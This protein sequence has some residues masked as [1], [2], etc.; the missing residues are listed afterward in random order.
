MSRAKKLIE[1]VRAGGDPMRV[2]NEM[3]KSMTYGNLP[4]KAEFEKAFDKEVPS[5]KYRFGNDERFGNDSVTS[6][7][8][9]KELETAVEEYEDG[10]DAAGDWASAVLSTLGFEWV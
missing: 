4:S 9:Y 10:D 7:E 3:M 6:N 5:G 1:D 2:V 8:L